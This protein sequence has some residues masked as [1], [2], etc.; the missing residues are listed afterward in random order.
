MFVCFINSA[1]R[2]AR[3]CFICCYYFL[4]K[5]SYKSLLVNKML[6]LMMKTNRICPQIDVPLSIVLYTSWNIKSM[7][8]ISAFNSCGL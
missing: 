3:H 8:Y 7:K 5:L 2:I 4:H 1:I 6:L